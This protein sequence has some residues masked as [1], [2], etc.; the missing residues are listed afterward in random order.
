M[1]FFI[2]LILSITMILPAVKQS[3]STLTVQVD[4]LKNKNGYIAIALFDQYGD[5]P[6]GDGVQTQYVEVNGS[7]MEVVFKDIEPGDYAVAILH[8]E[9]GNEEMDYNEYQMPLEGFGFSNN[10]VA[11]SGPPRFGDAAF[12]MSEDKVITIDLIYL[13]R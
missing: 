6:E 4:G 1:K 7:S 13:I 3:G 5:F 8:D 2:T 9:N 12:S 11:E 10:A